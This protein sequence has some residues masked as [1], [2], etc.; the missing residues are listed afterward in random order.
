MIPVEPI[1][2]TIGI[3]ALFSTCIE[4]FD[5]IKAAQSLEE[6]LERLLVKLDLE[7]TRLL[8]WGNAVGVLK[9][10]P[11]ERTPGLDDPIK[12]D[13][14]S[15][16][17]KC[18]KSLLSDADKL[19]KEYGLHAAQN[20]E[21][22]GDKNV[23]F[24]SSNSMNIFKISYKR[25][26][27]R[28]SATQDKAG[29]LSKTKWA[30]HNKAS[31]EGLIVHLKDFI[32]GLYQVIPVSRESQDRL[33]QDDMASILG[34]SK[35]QLVKEA[36][37]E[38]SYRAWSEMASV[39]IEESIKGTTDRRNFEELMRDIKDVDVPIENE[40]EKKSSKAVLLKFNTTALT[41]RV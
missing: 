24:V 25:F 14:I 4:C 1:S 36:C 21:S 32:D 10:V 9:D 11:E 33:I 15:G 12:V 13:S 17:L 5:Y 23:D 26:W 38:A 39:I 30:I 18:I 28:N 6:D 29:V 7:K 31:F 37:E 41:E 35:L 34:L 16:C 19:Q 40:K 3:A 27:A 2:L 8:I 20:T 22:K